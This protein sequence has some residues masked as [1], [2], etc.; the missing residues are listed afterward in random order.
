MAPT[1]IDFTITSKTATTV[2]AQFK[3]AD[4]NLVKSIFP[5]IN[6]N[7]EITLEQL[8][9]LEKIAAIG[10]QKDVLE[11]C[12]IDGINNLKNNIQND[13]ATL[14]RGP[15]QSIL[16]GGG[17]NGG[18]IYVKIPEGTNLKDIKSMYDL[19]DGSLRNYCRTAGYP[20]GNFDT[21]ETIADEVWFSVE[22]FAKGNNMTNKEVRA[23]FDK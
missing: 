14:A 21:Y 12:D 10:G 17:L 9:Y 16:F 18:F 1:T 6:A 4:K 2:K 11:S 7:N 23:L 13:E 19:P 5:E 15:I 8:Q 20:G 3:V 22:D